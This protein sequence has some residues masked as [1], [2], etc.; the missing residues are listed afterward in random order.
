MYTVSLV[1]PSISSPSTNAESKTTL[2][3][4][5]VEASNTSS[6]NPVSGKKH[7]GLALGT[8]DIEKP[9]ENTT[10]SSAASGTSGKHVVRVVEEASGEN[11]E[12]S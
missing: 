2:E 4:S 1:I 10:V 8:Q 5:V 7:A 9:S 11:S 6:L 3:T 12:K